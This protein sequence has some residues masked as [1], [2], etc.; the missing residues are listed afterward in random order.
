MPPGDS[1]EKA[2]L[3]SVERAAMIM[4]LVA[5]SPDPV[6][7]SDIARHLGLAKSTAHGLCETMARIDMLRR[8]PMGYQLGACSLR[9]SAAYLER[10]SLVQEFHS[11]IEREPALSGYTVTLSMLEHADVVYMACHNSGKPLGF[12]F[13]P[14][15]HLP[16]VFTATGKAMLSAMPAAERA[17]ILASAPWPAPFTANSVA[18]AQAFEHQAQRWQTLGYAMDEGEIREGMVCLG[19]AVPATPGRPMAGIAISMTRAEARSPLCHELGQQ[20]AAFA[21]RLSYI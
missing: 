19:A 20:M 16:A 6:G 4:D 8:G 11:L 14:G 18:D 12:T 17:A 1:L 10:T 2:R 9:W 7:V 13:Q 5:Q 3:N 15:Q 21:R